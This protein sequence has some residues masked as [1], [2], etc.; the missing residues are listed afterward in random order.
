MVNFRVE[1]LDELLEMMAADGVKVDEKR[2]DDEIGKF[3]WVYD[4]E[5]YKIELWEPSEQSK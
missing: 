2:M 3:A 4:P 1:G 5:G